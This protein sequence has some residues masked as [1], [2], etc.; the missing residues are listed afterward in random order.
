[1]G[2]TLNAFL[3]RG[4]DSILADKLVEKKITLN[5]LKSMSESQ[6]LKLGL[7]KNTVKDILEENR[8]PIPNDTLIKVLYESKWTCCVCR[9]GPKGIIVH[10]L[11][12]WSKS[13][14]H[15]EN[16]LIVLCLEHHGTV[17]TKS[18]LSLNLTKKKLIEFKKKWLKDVELA[19]TKTIL[20]LA[21][22]DY[23]RWD[24]FNHN[25][26]FEA[27]LNKKISNKGFR[28]TYTVKTLGL[29]NDLGTFA[30]KNEKQKNQI[31]NFNNGYMLY[32][33]MKELFDSVLKTI[34]LIDLTDKFN[35]SQI[36]SLIKPGKYIAI[37]AGFYFKDSNKNNHGKG[38][39]RLCYYQKNHIKIEFEFDAYETTST[40][41]WGSHLRGHKTVTPI[42]FVKSILE[43]KDML[44]ISVSCLAI[45]SYF[46]DSEHR[47]TNT[48]VS[49]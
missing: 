3:S 45:G 33:Y 29:I 26:I 48:T 49:S 8:P 39:T 7:Q 40:S 38:Q 27:Y 6:L 9:D 23:S 46:E 13:K 22:N 34:P 24:Y 43:E 18:D 1:M 20:G 15:S 17:H 25:R 21:T 36:L 19:D 37:Q 41:A 2:Q 35:R 44:V 16:N 5:K 30:I 10:H 4:I 14:D 32:Y 47:K 11:E 42:C 28:T 31:Y 12:E